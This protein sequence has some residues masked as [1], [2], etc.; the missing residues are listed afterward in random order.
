MQAA[1]VQQVIGISRSH[2]HRSRVVASFPWWESAIS[3]VVGSAA[4]AGSGQRTTRAAG[5]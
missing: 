1:S 4:V 2:R 3:L 5:S